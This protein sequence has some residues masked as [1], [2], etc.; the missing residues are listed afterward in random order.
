MYR[1]LSCLS[2]AVA[3]CGL[4]LA[5]KRDADVGAVVDDLNSFTQEIVKRV[6][7]NPNPS[8]GLDDAQKYFDSRKDEMTQ[9]LASIKNVR[10]AQVSEETKKK[11]FESV[12]NNV[13]SVS[14]L[15]IKYVGQTMRDP[16]L[17]GKLDKLLKDYTALLQSV[18][19]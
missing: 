5:C 18:G 9:K 2:L 4:A 10:E 3:L 14:K 8:A 16:A 11:M 7:S 1:K 12:Q 17:K 19:K 15:Q 13:M 6:E